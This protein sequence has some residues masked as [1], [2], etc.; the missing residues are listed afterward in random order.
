[1][2]YVAAYFP[3]KI[4]PK[5]EN[6]L[7]Y[8]SLK[9]LK[10]M[11]K[12]NSSLVVSNLGGGSRGH[13]GLVIPESKYSK[14]IGTTYKKPEHPGELKIQEN[15]ALHDAIILHKLQNKKIQLFC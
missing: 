6:R 5:I 2:G 9:K 11:I 7:T 8:E 3:F 12:V 14:I 10:K 4:L 1:M 15:T 13:L